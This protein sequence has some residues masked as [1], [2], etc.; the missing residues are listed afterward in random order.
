MK[1]EKKVCNQC[2]K[3]KW[4]SNSKGTCSDC[5]YL[6]SHGETRISSVLRKN[7]EKMGKMPVKK[8]KPVKTFKKPTGE[9]AMFKEIW[10]EREH[11]CNK[12]RTDL[13]DE[14]NIGYFSHIKSKGAHPN[15]R[16]IKTNV[17]LLCLDCHHIWDH[18]DRNKL[19]DSQN[20]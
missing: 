13:G 14:P 18:G 6:K 9:L 10:E 11:I 1:P 5:V 19:K 17:E 8:K 4:I 3:E 15:L 12:C 16:L 20:G 7:K 2:G